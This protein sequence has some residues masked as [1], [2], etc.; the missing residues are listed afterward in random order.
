[1]F[2]ELIQETLAKFGLVLFV[3]GIDLFAFI[4]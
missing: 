4:F 1:V 3:H 2:D